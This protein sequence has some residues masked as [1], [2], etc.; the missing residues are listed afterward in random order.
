MFFGSAVA[1]RKRPHR[2]LSAEVYNTAAMTDTREALYLVDGMSHI[3]R[4]YYAIRGLSTSSGLATNAVYGFTMMLR[5]LISQEKPKYLGIVLDSAEPT[6]R[7][8]AFA[9]YKAT[10]GLMP[11]DLAAQI[12]YILRVCEVFRLPVVRVPGFEAD[13]LIGTLAHKAEAAGIETVIVSQDKDLCQLVTDRV[14]I[15]REERDRTVTRVDREGVV[16]RM[17]VPPEQVIDLLGLQGDASDNIPGAP[18]IGEKGALQILQQFGSIDSALA[19]WESVSRKSYRES[20]R[21]NVDIIRL[22]KELA[23]IKVDCDIELDLEDLKLSDPDAVAAQALFAELEINS[24][25][26]EFEKLAGGSAIPSTAPAAAAA[27]AYTSVSDKAAI[28]REI[29]AATTAGRVAL[30]VATDGAGQVTGIA[31]SRA[32]EKGVFVDVRNSGDPAAVIGAVASLC[33]DDRVEKVV[34]DAKTALHGLNRLFEELNP[35]RKAEVIRSVTTCGS[36]YPWTGGVRLSPIAEDTLIAAYLLDPNRGKYPVAEVAREVLGIEENKT[37]VAGIDAMGL[38]AI[39]EADATYR[40][41]TELRQ[42]MESKGLLDVYTRLELPLVELLYEI[43]RIGLRLDP[44]ALAETGKSMD[45]EMARLAEKIYELAGQTFNINSPSQLGD[46][47]ERLNF[48]MKRRTATGKI[49][50][51][52]DILEE[53]A[54]DFELPRLVIE[55]RELA[56]LKG[57]Y[58]EALPLSIDGETGRVH[59]SLNQAGAATG[60]LSS[61]NP[62]LQNIPVRSEAG[63]AIRRAFVAPDGCEFVSVDYSQIELRVLAHIAEDERMREAFRQ[64][65]DIHAATAREVFGATTLADEKEKR[66]LAKIVNF[67]IAYGVGAFG[68][69]QRTGLSRKQAREA[70][71]R[72]FASFT[73]VRR[74]M[75]ETPVRARETGDVRTLFGRLRQIPDIDNKNQNLR[76]RAEREAINMPIQG[77][78]ADL[79]KLAMIAAREALAGSNL[80]ARVVMQ[81]HD[82]LLIEAAVRDVEAT[83]DLVKR[84]MECAYELSVPLVVDVGSGPNWM[85]AK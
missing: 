8:E 48:P 45:I 30:S 83:K 64:D 47:L 10:R 39:A 11:D 20:L 37:E 63:R 32:A 3:F 72:Y 66:R 67:A 5:K 80:S 69:A 57:T 16:K 50:T 2:R 46:V 15:M 42:R 84:A 52:K 22:S 60:R 41:A 1:R 82:E 44:V 18:G 75:D 78:A 71:E 17:G 68:L 61:S 28:D 25:A 26:K 23:T 77:T 35:D 38:R 73:G 62:N 54:V 34:H 33:M 65:E 9:D 85:A 21:D 24:L 6:F 76:A 31:L 81:V 55:Y 74:Y 19:G 40:L 56:K 43:E 51:S 79:M 53:L 7:H 12:P 13:D 29:A 59:T 14:T 70:I 4:A 49:S 36:R 27:R 58:V